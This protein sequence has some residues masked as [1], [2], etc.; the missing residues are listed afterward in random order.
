MPH[1][2]VVVG[3]GGFGTTMTALAAGVPQVVVPRSL[4]RTINADR[5]AAIGAGIHLPGGPAAVSDIPAALTRVLPD[6]GYRD[7]ARAVA[8]DIA[9]LPDTTAS[10]PI[11]EQLAA[12]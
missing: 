7:A 4:D 2:G 1:T 10:V 5:V 6:R 9:Q 8:A 12:R 11:L 3:H